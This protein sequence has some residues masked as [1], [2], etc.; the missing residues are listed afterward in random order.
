MLNKEKD[1]DF[2]S[3]KE[4][5]L[6]EKNN[7][8]LKLDKKQINLSNKFSEGYKEFLNKSKTERVAV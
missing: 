5:L 7:R 2:E 8:C 1:G 3:L 6:A 4:K